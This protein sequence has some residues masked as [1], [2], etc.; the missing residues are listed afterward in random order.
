MY[1]TAKNAIKL[2]YKDIS[3]IELGVAGGNGINS[4][5]NYKKKIEVVVR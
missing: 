3:I 5:I 2:G 4:L 1:E